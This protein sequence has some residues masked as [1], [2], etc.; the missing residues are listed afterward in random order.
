MKAQRQSGFTLIELMVVVAIIG[1][2]AVLAVDIGGS[3][4]NASTTSDRVAGSLGFARMRAMATRTTH[5]VQVES[6]TVSLWRATTTGLAA[7]V[8]WQRLS[9]ESLPKQ[10]KVWNALSTV[11]ATATGGPTENAAVLM[12]IDFKPDGTATGGTVY[13]TDNRARRKY[14]VLVY[15]ATGGTYI[16]ENW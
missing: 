13:V 5:R 2:I 16:R 14:R 8:G 12:T 9:I 3:P 7:P 1:V 10:T 6:Q 4:A 11:A 15:R